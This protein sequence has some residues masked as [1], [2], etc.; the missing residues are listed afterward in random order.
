MK[1]FTIISAAVFLIYKQTAH[2]LVAPCP[3]Q[4]QSVPLFQVGDLCMAAS[5][6]SATKTLS[7]PFCQTWLP[8]GHKS[9]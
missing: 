2:S 3:S 6:Q 7:C 8:M 1:S 9:F 5:P 4:C